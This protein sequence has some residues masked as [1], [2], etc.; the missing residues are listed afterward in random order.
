MD[1]FDILATIVKIAIFMGVVLVVVA[2]LVWSERKISAAIQNRIG[3]NR[4][5]F[6]GLLQPFADLIK[7][8]NKEI[9]VPIRSNRYLFIVAPLFSLAPAAATELPST[10]DMRN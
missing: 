7:M 2:E 8:L 5:G 4:V 1:L 3:P 10:I 6:R 9:I